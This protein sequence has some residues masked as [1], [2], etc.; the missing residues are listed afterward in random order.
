MSCRTLGCL[1]FK[2][3][4][5]SFWQFLSYVRAR[6]VPRTPWL[7]D[8]LQPTAQ[9]FAAEYPVH[10]PEAAALANPPGDR[11][12]AVW[13][14]H[15]TLLVQMDG[16]TF[17]TDP[18][19]SERCSP[20][21]FMGPRRVVPPAMQPL[22]ASFPHID[23]IVLSH[24]HYDHLDRPSVLRLRDK[25]GDKLRWYVPLR[26]GKWFAAAGI[27]NVV[28]MDWW[29]EVQHPGSSVT[30]TMTPAQHWSVRV[31]TPLYSDKR[32]T[33][34]GGYAIRGRSG[35]FWFAGDTGYC[36]VFKEIGSRLGP[37][38]LSAIPIG[39]YEP[40]WFMKPQ[41]C[42]PEEAV[43]I[44]KEVKSKRSIGIHCATFYLADDS[45]DAPY[46]ELQE[47]A[48]SQGLS[49]GE[50]AVPQ[51]GVLLRTGE[52]VPDDLLLGTNRQKSG[53]GKWSVVTRL[54]KSV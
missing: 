22:D 33:L 46:M 32:R 11:I 40:R 43:T 10:T 19:F 1:F 8:N 51:H 41:H 28:E 53:E 4:D 39:A 12:Q 37:F 26:L 18:I 42:S 5:R 49:T 48:E 50:F 31:S 7:S 14:G 29:D 44:H 15:A 30:I 2:A 16:L 27:T 20:I 24:N 47:A 23:F 25:F 6:T 21:S 9:D 54:Q 52:K 13:I 45:M 38:D 3:S 17:L 35:S 36:P 34:W